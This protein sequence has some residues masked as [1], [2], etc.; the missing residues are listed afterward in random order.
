[1]GWEWKKTRRSLPLIPGVN[2]GRLLLAASDSGVSAIGIPREF[3]DPTGAYGG[4]GVV[5]RLYCVLQGW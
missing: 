2:V 5:A 4:C 1:M 3:Q